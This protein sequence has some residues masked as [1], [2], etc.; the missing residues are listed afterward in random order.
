MKNFPITR[1]QLFLLTVIFVG[2]ISIIPYFVLAP[3]NQPNHDDFEYIVRARESGILGVQKSYYEGWSGRYSST[4]VMTTVP[5]LIGVY[6][7]AKLL[8]FLIIMGYLT[9]APLLVKELVPKI[10]LLENL[11][12]SVG[13]VTFFLHWL[14]GIGDGF[15][16]PAGS[17]NYQIPIILL[18]VQLLIIKRYL[19]QSSK[20]TTY[21]LKLV[22]LLLTFTICG[23]NETLTIS[24]MIISTTLSI[25]AY[26]SKN[27]FLTFLI[28]N[29]LL[30]LI[31]LTILAI[32]PGNAARTAGLKTISTVPTLDI[33]N[34]I[35]TAS[36]QS[37]EII[38]Y[39]ILNP[40]FLCIGAMVL[41]LTRYNKHKAWTLS[42]KLLLLSLIVSVW[43]NIF[44]LNY[45]TGS[46]IYTRVFNVPFVLILITSFYL[47]GRYGA[48]FS[49]HPYPQL[50]VVL[51]IVATISIPLL[52]N[53][54]NN[55]IEDIST[56]KVVR[57]SN[58]FE[59][60][61]TELKKC[62]LD[63][64]DYCEIVDIRPNS[65]PKSFYTILWGKEDDYINRAMGRYHG[66]ETINVS[67]DWREL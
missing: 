45:L 39:I 61:K 65:D 30:T 36:S 20:E 2:A 41:Y 37:I 26:L 35:F 9:I 8:P 49:L 44:V 6:A 40:V 17:I 7:N 64:A 55:S 56:G 34:S 22:L 27:K 60:M 52:S 24:Y 66:V 33:Y 59:Y 5:Q 31:S 10:T 43:V 23:F 18:L 57:Y 14:P 58:Y 4:F 25:G 54:F 47:L 32:A 16:W 29:N 63:Q 3:Y 19:L 42:D 50:Q 46:T 15:F 67:S 11:A 12:T 13:I 53:N 62:N 1:K 38:L 51:L 21:K 48:S 28:L